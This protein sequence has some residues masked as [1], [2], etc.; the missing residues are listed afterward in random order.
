VVVQGMGAMNLS[1]VP[2]SPALRAI[3]SCEHELFR[4]VDPR[5]LADLI[6][7]SLCLVVAPGERLMSLGATEGCMYFVLDG[8][9]SVH[10]DRVDRP[11]V[12]QVGRGQVV[13]ELSLL[14]GT[15]SSAHVVAVERT[16]VLRVEE[17]AFWRLVMR[18]HPFA[19]NLLHLVARR[20]RANNTAMIASNKLLERFETE[21]RV[22]ALT[23]THN[24]RWL[25]DSLTRY[26]QRHRRDATPLSVLLVDVDHFKRINDGLGHA[27][28]DR[29]LR[30]VAQTL[31]RCLRPGDRVARYGGEEFVVILPH[32]ALEGA[33]IAAERLRVEI[34]RAPMEEPLGD[35]GL[36]L[37][38]SIGAATLAGAEEA[39]ALLERADARLYAAKRNGRNR[40]ET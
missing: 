28:G 25:D 2:D 26:V 33:R 34:T 21:A 13:G 19:T 20:L 9:L 32:T 16:N 1:P 24:R 35:P 15:A 7:A 10:L 8:R 17:I 22:D 31:E 36:P 38:V 30:H 3:Q 18:S 39:P 40:V 37:H 5:A 27:A 12:A 29:V 23:G 14:L 4:G 11:P 6:E